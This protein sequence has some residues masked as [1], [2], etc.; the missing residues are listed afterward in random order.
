MLKIWGV[1][2]ECH[3]CTPGGYLEDTGMNHL[4]EKTSIYTLRTL[5]VNLNNNQWRKAGL[6]L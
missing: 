1:E 4:V 5:K 2:K 6:N 3:V